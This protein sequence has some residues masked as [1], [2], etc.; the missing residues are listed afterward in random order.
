MATKILKFF[1]YPTGFKL[2]LLRVLLESA[3]NELYL[4]TKLYK[5]IKHLHINQENA[6]D[7]EIPEHELPALSQM[8]KA[9]KLVEKFA[10]W[11]PMCYNRAL[12][13]KNILAKKGIH[14]NLHIGFRK[15]DGE[16]DGH[17]WITYRG[18]FV[19]GLLPGIKSFRELESIT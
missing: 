12:T 18:K 5:P 15:K 14:T 4:K 17:A 11:K 8:S 13:A 1:K 19:T 7:D 10:P 6:M 2:L 16:F 9:M 3:K